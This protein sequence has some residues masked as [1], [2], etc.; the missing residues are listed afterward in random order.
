MNILLFFLSPLSIM[1]MML[2]SLATECTKSAIYSSKD[3][4]IYNYNILITGNIILY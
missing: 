2:Y 4:I 1:A 3:N